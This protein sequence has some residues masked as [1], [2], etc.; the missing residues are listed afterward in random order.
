[1]HFEHRIQGIQA[2]FDLKRQTP[3]GVA[4]M[5]TEGSM[6]AFKEGGETTV[7]LKSKLQ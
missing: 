5:V 2:E 7:I 3:R 4:F 6:K 1:M